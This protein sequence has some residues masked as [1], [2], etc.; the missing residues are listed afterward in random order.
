[1]IATLSGVVN[2][3]GA[4]FCLLDVGGIGFQIYMPL[5]ALEEL[6]TV[7]GRITIQVYLHHREDAMTLYGFL[8]PEEKRLFTQ[9]IGVSGIGPK[10]ALAILSVLSAERFCQAILSEDTSTLTEAPGIG[11]K[12]AQRLILELKAKISKSMTADPAWSATPVYTGNQVVKD[13]IDALV[14]LGYT[15]T[16]AAETVGKAYHGNSSLG[17]PELVRQALKLLV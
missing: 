14:A 12:S 3:V 4:D 13:A 17:V 7:E 1:M 10:T 2:Q 11:L 8:K 16:V 6:A 9:I 5:T 15:P